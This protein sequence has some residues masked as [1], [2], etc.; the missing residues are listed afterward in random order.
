MVGHTCHSE[1]NCL[2]FKERDLA[3]VQAVGSFLHLIL[4][5][6]EVERFGGFQEGSSFFVFL[7][8]KGKVLY[9]KVTC[10]GQ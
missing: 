2:L 1:V 10:K 9:P 4:R 7:Q 8:S 5:P 3:I 6:K